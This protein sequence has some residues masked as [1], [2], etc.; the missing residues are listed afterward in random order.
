MRRKQAAQDASHRGQVLARAAVAEVIQRERAARDGAR[1]NEMATYHH[2]DSMID[3]AWF[4][5][6]GQDFVRATERNW[7]TDA[8]NFHEVGPAAVIVNGDRAIAETACT[9]HGFYKLD[10]VD[11]T[12]TGYIRLL[13][14]AKRLRGKWLIAGL[15]GLYIRDLLQ[16][17]SP[18]HRLGLDEL[19]LSTFRDSYRY[20]T[21]TLKVLG[22]DPKHDLPGVDR[23][24]SIAALRKEEELWLA[25]LETV[26]QNSEWK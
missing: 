12:S 13:W 21:H 11:V 25:E 5:G 24:E 3:V 6:S 17:C 10:G 26:P 18:S 4:R 7:R 14:R 23:P 22:R 15:R 9:L 1:W 2:P 16:P 19:E 20:L 8:V